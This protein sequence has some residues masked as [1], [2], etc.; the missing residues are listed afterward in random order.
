MNSWEAWKA[1]GDGKYAE[2]YRILSEFMCNIQIR[3]SDSRFN[4]GWMRA[5]D[6]DRDEYFG[7]NGDTGWGP[8]C[9]ESGWTNAIASAGL[10]LGLLNESLF[11]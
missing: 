10:L 7:N 6:M 9:I 4:G 2:L 11:E 8:Y 1:T 3:S 5:Y